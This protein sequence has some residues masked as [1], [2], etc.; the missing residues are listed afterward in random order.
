[1]KENARHPNTISNNHITFSPF[2]HM[3]CKNS[4]I[5]GTNVF[6]QHSLPF[7]QVGEYQNKN[8]QDPVVLVPE[9]TVEMWEQLLADEKSCADVEL[10]VGKETEKPRN[11]L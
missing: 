2:S 11:V 4:H 10:E 1:M 5:L 3:K 6:L 9:G 8:H 7:N